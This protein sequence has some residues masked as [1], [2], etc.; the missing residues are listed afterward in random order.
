MLE[1]TYVNVFGQELV[2]NPVL[3]N[4]I[5]VHA[6]AGCRRTEK[7]SKQSRNS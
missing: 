1:A 4:D 5:V 2:G 6:R 7:E 3:V